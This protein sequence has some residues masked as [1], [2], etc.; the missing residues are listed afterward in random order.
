METHKSTEFFNE[1][2]QSAP[3]RKP[4]GSV[5]IGGMLLGKVFANEYGIS[6]DNGI[7]YRNG[8]EFDSVSEKPYLV[9]DKFTWYQGRKNIY[10]V[11]NA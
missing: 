2:I 10:I 7:A 3:K 11:A 8:T 4:L 1:L 5:A 6:I 9:N